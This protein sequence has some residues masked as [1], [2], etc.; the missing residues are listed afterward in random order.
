MT[1]TPASS[2]SGTIAW[3]RSPRRWAWRWRARR[4]RPTSRSGATTRARCSTRDGRLVAQAAHIPVHLGSTALSVAAVLERVPLGD[5]EVA[6][7]NDPYAGGTHLPDVTLVRAGV[8]RRARCS[9]TSPTAR[10]TPTSAAARRARCRSACARA[11]TTLPEAPKSMPAAMSPRYATAR[12]ARRSRRAP[13]TID[14]EGLRIAA[15]AARRRAW[16]TSCA[17]VARAPDE[18]RGD[19]AA[20]RAAL[21]VGR[22]RLHALAA[23]L[24][25]RRAGGARATALIGYS[26]GAVARRDRAPSPTASTRSPIR[27][28]TTAPAGTTWAFACSLTIDGDRAIVDFSD[29]DDEVAGPLNAVYAVTLSAVLYAFRLLLP[30]DA[31]TNHGLYAPLEVIAP[32][33]SRAQRAAAARRRGRQRRDLAAHRRRGARRAGAGA[34]RQHS[35]GERRHDVQPAPR[36]RRAAPTTRPSAAAPARHRR[37]PAPARPDPHDQHAQHAGRGARARA[38][39]ARA[40]LRACGAARAAAARTPAATASSAS[41][42]C[43]ATPTVTLVG[44]RRRRPPYGLSGGGPGTVGEDTLAARRPHRE[45]PGKITFDARAGD[46]SPSRRPAAA[47][48]AIRMRAKFWASRA[49]ET[50]LSQAGTKGRSAT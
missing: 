38:A 5:G 16:S 19:L 47:A 28:T 12:R 41:S 24:R 25:R 2:R 1:T 31:P 39:G 29:S 6:I 34:A 32:D 21:E 7:V 26:R 50:E 48:T 30:E 46:R 13:V 3:R 40:A 49:V 44:E 33:G 20:Q 10:T 22:R 9:A 23:T 15:D 36:R 11:A 27:S 18:R 14:D 4:S 37:R 17:R 35:V 42:S 45:L 43:C 8:R